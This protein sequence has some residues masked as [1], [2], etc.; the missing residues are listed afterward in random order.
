MNNKKNI[1]IADDNMEI[2]NSFKK[3]F[4]KCED[5]NISIANNGEEVL[6]LLENNSIDALLC[7]IIMP[8]LDG[9]GVIKS[10]NNMELK[11]KPHI[12]VVSSIKK[13][14]MVE[15]VLDLGVDFY[16][17]KPVNIDTL[18]RRTLEIMDSSEENK[19]V[20]AFNDNNIQEVNSILSSSN[21]DKKEMSYIDCSGNNLEVRITNLLHE[22]G[23]PAHVKG[24]VFLRDSIKM[25][26]DDMTLLNGITKYLYPS[27]ASKHETT[28]TRVERAI[29]HA[30]EVAWKAPSE[31]SSNLFRLSYKRN[32]PTNSE[33]IA[34]VSDKVRLELNHAK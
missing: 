28:S 27:I 20:I 16:M 14:S 3:G 26:V 4:E 9:I 25:V 34:V 23:I 10:I 31:E 11:K 22:I 18:V 6:D 1:I 17:M 19:E 5:V 24:Y 29:R 21:P 12:I 8:E 7:D 33:F 2:A 32:K 15:K 13:D 30:I